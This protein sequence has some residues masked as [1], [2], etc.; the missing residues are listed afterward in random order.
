MSEMEIYKDALEKIV[1]IFDGAGDYELLAF[2]DIA[3]KA[4]KTGALLKDCKP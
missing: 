3:E 1:A 2:L 4:L